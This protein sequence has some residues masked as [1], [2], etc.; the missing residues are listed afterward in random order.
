MMKLSFSNFVMTSDAF[1]ILLIVERLFC[2]KNKNRASQEK[3]ILRENGSKLVKQGV[4]NRHPAVRQKEPVMYCTY[5]LFLGW[6]VQKFRL[7]LF[8]C[9]IKR[10]SLAANE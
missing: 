1:C 8:H 7:L 10:W 9:S 5:M 6:R 2:T 3:F 4:R